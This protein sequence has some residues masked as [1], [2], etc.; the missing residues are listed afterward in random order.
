MLE[1]L[2]KLNKKYNNKY[3]NIKI[4]EAIYNSNLNEL[5]IKINYNS[6]TISIKEKS[7]ITEFFIDY[8]NNVITLKSKNSNTPLLIKEYNRLSTNY[9]TTPVIYTSAWGKKSIGSFSYLDIT[10]ML[11]VNNKVK[12]PKSSA[13]LYC[14][15]TLVTPGSL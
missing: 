14:K 15:L 9:D 3:L 1:I 2:Q 12:G 8:F 10:E 4:Y 7:E 5:T 11:V 13:F 6:E